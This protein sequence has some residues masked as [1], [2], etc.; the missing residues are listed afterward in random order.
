MGHVPDTDLGFNTVLYSLI[1][2]FVMWG[3][4]R[5]VIYFLFLLSVFLLGY[6][7][8]NTGILHNSTFEVGKPVFKAYLYLN[9]SSC[10]GQ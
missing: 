3:K 6:R 1:L 4:P 5:T 10:C 9:A 7:F 8:G 2:L